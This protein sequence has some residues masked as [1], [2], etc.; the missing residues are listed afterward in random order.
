MTAGR[1]GGIIVITIDESNNIEVSQYDTF[2]LRVNFSGGYTMAAGDR[3][4]FAI[5]NTTNSTDVVYQKDFRNVGST[6]VDVVIPKGEL[7]S[8]MADAYV[9]DITLINDTTGKIQTLI[10]SASFIIRGV[11]HNVD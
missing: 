3:L 6:Y 1:N 11:A 8:L 7:N 10:W 9:Y 5:K 4:R 2:S